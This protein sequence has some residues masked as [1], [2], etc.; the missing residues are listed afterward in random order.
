MHLGRLTLTCMLVSQ[1]LHR[2]CHLAPVQP[3]PPSPPPPAPSALPL[4]ASPSSPRL[5]SEICSCWHTRS[6]GSLIHRHMPLVS[7]PPNIIPPPAFSAAAH[8]PGA[9]WGLLESQNRPASHAPFHPPP[10]LCLPEV[11]LTLFLPSSD[12]PPCCRNQC[13]CHPSVV[14]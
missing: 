9:P 4:A 12:R 7:C 8:R 14:P 3:Q 5:P 13:I 11:P 2:V 6:P 10:T 1:A